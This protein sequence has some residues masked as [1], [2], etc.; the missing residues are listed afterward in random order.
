MSKS[1]LKNVLPLQ[2]FIRRQQVLGLFREFNRAVR[3]I[4]DDSL[5]I[6][7]KRQILSDFKQNMNMN[8]N[9]IVRVL[10]QEAQRHLVMLQ[11]MGSGSS[12]LKS[13]QPL[14]NN[15]NIDSNS[16]LGMDDPEDPRG[17]VGVKWPWNKD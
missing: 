17:R 1:R 13:K 5:R 7:L 3:L 16:W 2:V 6:D 10:I 9:S 12:K 15:D 4:P 11:S 14:N 8:E